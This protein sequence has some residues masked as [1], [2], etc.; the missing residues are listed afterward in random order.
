MFLEQRHLDLAAQ[1]KA[2]GDEFLAPIE[3]RE[4]GVDELA[5]SILRKLGDAGFTR[6]S[7]SGAYGGHA[8]PL[9]VRALCVI[10]E[11]LA[12]RMG[13]ADF[14]FAMQGLGSYPIALAGSEAQKKRLLPG[15]ASGELAAAFALTEPEAGS[16][17]GALACSA[18]RV[19]DEWIVNGRKRFISNAPI[20]GV[21][22]LF[23]RTGEGNKGV[24]A[25]VVEA[26]TPGVRIEAQ[27]PIAPH[28]IGEVIFE[29]AR[30]PASALLGAEGTGF[31]VALTTLD[32]FRTTVGAAALGMAQRAQDEAIAH[33]KSR[34]QFGAPLADLQG[35]QFLLADSEVELEA[36]RL[37]VHRAAYVKDGG[38]A[39]VTREAAIAKL[40]ATENAQRVIDRS[41]QLHG[42]AGVM[43]GTPVERLY[44]EVRA[45]RIYEGATEVQKLVIARE[46]LKMS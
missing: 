13:L 16:D 37:L 33:V 11:Q 38:A 3:H 30:L 32:V 46:R 18:R 4:D 20:F 8:D 45:L 34:K 2:F 6:W 10:R 27:E 25:F 15:V 41:V 12:W 5:K 42:G 26:G 44:R 35:V 36:A 22:S 31:K 19:G 1:V 14:C 7:V 29:D 9:D 39:R 43:R 17:A 23:A 21:M 24:S 28:P 40:V